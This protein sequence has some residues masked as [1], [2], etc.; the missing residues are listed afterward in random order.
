MTT[1]QLAWLIYAAGL[2]AMAYAA[3]RNIEHRAEIN[4]RCDRGRILHLSAM[5]AAA[6]V[7]YVTGIIVVGAMWPGLVFVIPIGRWLRRKRRCP[8]CGKGLRRKDAA[9]LLGRSTS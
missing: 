3:H 6:P 4:C 8:D 7:A 1:S 9:G 5:A 2:V